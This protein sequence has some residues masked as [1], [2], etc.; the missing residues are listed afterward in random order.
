MT[1]AL[2]PKLRLFTSAALSEGGVVDLDKDQAH[3]LRN[4]MRAGPG[5][6]VAL[7]NGRDGEWRAEVDGLSKSS[8]L[9]RVTSR[10]RVQEP[11]SDLWLLFA[12]LKKD[13][14]D[15]LVEK[16]TELGVSVLWPVITRHTVAQRV[17]IE[18][19]TAHAREAAEQCERLT[20]PEVREPVALEKA[21]AAWPKE[22]LLFHAD[23]S[24]KGAPIAQALT[25]RKEAPHAFLIGP[26]GGFAPAELDLLAQ[27]AFVVP[28]GLGPRLLRAETAA[29][30][31]LSCRQALCGAWDD[32]PPPRP[33]L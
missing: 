8:G 12:P 14:V 1:G 16:A 21:L 26:E 17:N 7:F 29:L 33:H 25:G 28:I 23:E 5:E 13:P 27:C 2:R 4:V 20:A 6:A 30:A 3:Y 9:L 11:G 31:A 24:G 19:L 18:R 22:R 32:R 10:L 15:W